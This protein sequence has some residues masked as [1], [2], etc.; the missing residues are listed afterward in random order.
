MLVAMTATA[1][2]SYMKQSESGWPRLGMQTGR[3]TK[4]FG[5]PQRTQK[6]LTGL[7]SLGFLFSY[8]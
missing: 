6:I 4:E 2:C 7:C 5:I 3:T 1:N 8:C